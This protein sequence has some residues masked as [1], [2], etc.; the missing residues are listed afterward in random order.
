MI[1]VPVTRPRVGADVCNV[2]Y[3][4]SLIF[5]G[6]QEVFQSPIARSRNMLAGSAGIQYNFRFLVVERETLKT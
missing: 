1:C 5:G 4:C 2:R 6:Y 3:A